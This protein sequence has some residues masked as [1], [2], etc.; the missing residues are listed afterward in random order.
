MLLQNYWLTL[1]VALFLPAL[2]WIEARADLPALR[3]VALAVSALV[4][5][6]LV[7]NWYV[8]DYAFGTI[9]LA[10]GLVAGYAFPA[11]A[12]AFASLLFRRRDDDLLVATLEAGTVTLLALFVA[13][14]IRHWSGGGSLAQPAGFTEIALHL[15]TTAVQA[16]VY[17]YLAQRTGRLVLVWAWKVLG[18]VALVWGIGVI[19][20]N[21]MATGAPAGVLTL[22]AAYFAPAC[23]AALAQSR[24]P[25]T[26]VRIGLGG[27]AVVAGLAWITLQIRQFFHPD[28]MALSVAPI[29]AAELWGWSGGWLAFGIGLMVQ[30]I[31]TGERLL[32]LTALGVMGLVCIKVF[33]I[34]MSGLTGLWRVLSFLGL[35]MALIGLGVVYRRF[36][37]P[38]QQG[39]TG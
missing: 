37:V 34:D 25:D 22:F 1:A 9:P 31:R 8:L 5:I 39:Q 21:P 18:G 23:F 27:Y 4:I 33:A 30:G 20:L 16:T 13:L 6:R 24:M 17:L 38:A 19:V 28:G 7:L 26:R 15:L 2:A 36:V 35:G 14:E 29:E 10:N 11:A 32:R 12:F 3:R